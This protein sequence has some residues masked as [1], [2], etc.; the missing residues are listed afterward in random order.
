MSRVNAMFLH[1]SS[2]SPQFSIHRET[3]SDPTDDWR[4]RVRAICNAMFTIS[5]REL[6]S[7]HEKC[8]FIVSHYC[9]YQCFNVGVARA[10]LIIDLFD[11]R[12]IISS[13]MRSRNSFYFRVKLKRSMRRLFHSSTLLRLLFPM[14]ILQ[15][16][17]LKYQVETCYN[18]R[19]PSRNSL[20][21]IKQNFFKWKVL[22]NFDTVF[23][24]LM[25]S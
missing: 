7:F 13:R 14:T 10:H 19:D 23:G 15:V 2:A 6:D 5:T 11:S 25:T 4:C 3:E 17:F 22:S 12:Y 21:I 1:G 8:N 20:K 24:C 16:Y 18:N 9:V